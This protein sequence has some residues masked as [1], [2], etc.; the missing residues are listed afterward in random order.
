ML[1]DPARSMTTHVHISYV[2]D[3]CRYVAIDDSNAVWQYVQQT[4]VRVAAKPLTAPPPGEEGGE[5]E[6][7][8]E[9]RDGGGCSGGGG[10]TGG[11]RLGCDRSAHIT[12][13]AGGNSTERALLDDDCPELVAAGATR[14]A[15][16]TYLT[17]LFTKLLSLLWQQQQQQPPQ[18]ASDGD[19]DR[20][21][22]LSLIHI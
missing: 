1:P 5:E 10:G 13:G 2:W 8:R 14:E 15:I 12:N 19:A 3:E 18:S 6:D 16:R 11:A 7:Q 21:G 20:G 17:D 22:D 4:E 9:G